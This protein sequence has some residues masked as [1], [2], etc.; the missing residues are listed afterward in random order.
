MKSKWQRQR[1]LVLLLAMQRKGKRGP[2]LGRCALALALGQKG[3]RTTGEPLL[4]ALV[5]L[6]PVARCETVASCYWWLC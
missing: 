4:V 3:K 6:C 2:L 5:P 1:S